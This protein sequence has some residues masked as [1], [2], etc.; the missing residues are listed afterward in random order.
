M[1]T[2]NRSG[3][4]RREFA[5]KM[6]VA[7][8]GLPLMGSFIPTS[9]PSAPENIPGS[10]SGSW[11]IHLFSKHL[12][13]L[14]YKEMAKATVEAGLDGVDLTVRPGGHVLPENVERDL[15]RGFFKHRRPQFRSARSPC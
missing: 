9:M 10:D 5:R 11:K 2:L 13:F 12:Q 15:C 4:N 7:A 3:Q 14:G 6:A 1:E 8:M